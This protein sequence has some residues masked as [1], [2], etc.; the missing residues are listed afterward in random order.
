MRPDPHHVPE[1]D[2]SGR[3]IYLGD[4]RRRKGRRRQSPDQH[5][6]IA[7]AAC[8]LAGWG[9]WLAVILSLA[10]SRLLTYLAFFLP[11]SFALAA[12]GTLAAYAVEWRRELLPSLVRAGSRGILF[13]AVVVTNLTFQAA[14]RWTPIVTVVA[15]AIAVLIDLG[16]T[17]RRM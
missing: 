8:A 17:W 3:I 2:D 15:L 14:H 7:L 4:V 6:L 11:L 9:V 1:R 12:T 10:P 13:A 16:I 5:Y